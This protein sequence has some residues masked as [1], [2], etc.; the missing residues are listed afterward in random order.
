MNKKGKACSYWIAVLLVGLALGVIAGLAI[1]GFA[2]PI[3]Q[4]EKWAAWVQAFGSIGAIL[5]AIA[6]A[7][8]QEQKRERRLM[9]HKC[10]SES[11]FLTLL[12]DCIGSLGGIAAGLEDGSFTSDKETF[13]L[14]DQLVNRYRD[15]LGALRA[16]SMFDPNF[17]AVFLST[18]DTRS[19]LESAE[20]EMSAFLLEGNM[21]AHKTFDAGRLLRHYHSGAKQNFLF[22]LEKIGV[23]LNE[24]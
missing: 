23:D 4:S 9:R 14:F 12:E 15:K 1:A 20:Y 19:L 3:Y 24:T 7:S 17:T 5:A 11:A 18:K 13:R 16:V 10:E 22:A 21:I 6:I 8:H 2:Y